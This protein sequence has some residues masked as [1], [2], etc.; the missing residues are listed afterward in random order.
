V[1]LQ[2]KSAVLR[3]SILCCAT[4]F[5]VCVA[6]ATTIDAKEPIRIQVDAT[7]TV[8]KV[9]SVTEFIPL[10]DETS[11]TLLYPRWEVASHAPTISVADLAGLELVLNGKPLEWQRDPVDVHA[12]HVALPRKASVLEAHFQYLSSID[13]PVLSR[14]IVQVQWQHLMLYPRGMNVNEIP[15]LAQLRLPTGFRAASSLRVEKESGTVLDFWQCTVGE[16]ADAPVF[17]GRFLRNWRLS[18]DNAKPVWLHVVADEAKDLTISSEQLQAL[19]KTVTL[20][21]G[22]FGAVPFRH[23]DFLVAVTDQLP[24][25]GGAEHQESSEISLPADYFLRPDK[26]KA[27]ASLFPHEYIHAWNGL[28]HR[29]AGLVVPDFNTPMQNSMLWVY[30]GLTELWGLQIAG[31]SGLI[32]DQDYRDL[33][34]MDAA[35]QLSRPG[36]QWKS[37]ADSDYDPVYLAG[38]HTTWR[39]WERRE[40]YYTEG[41]LLWLGVDAQIRRLTDGRKTLK[42]FGRTFFAAGQIPCVVV[43]YSFPD[44]ISGLNGIAPF[45]WLNCLLVQLN[46]HDGEHLLDD[47]KDA[48][49]QLVFSPM[50]SAIFAQQEQQDGAL[51]L[52][53]SIGARIR[54]NGLVQ[55]VS[56]HSSAFEAGMVPGMRI[57]AIDG[58]TF[59][60]DALRT[61]LQSNSPAR[62]SLTVTSETGEVEEISFAYRAGLR[63]PH[64][65]RNGH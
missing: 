11:I 19:R 5:V 6:R 54:Q 42:D 7:D 63:F 12:F 29:P 20:T 41:P 2:F 8:H 31:E 62:I 15:V 46:A 40:D 17:A 24:S 61:R 18:T 27:M 48:N 1:L 52:S 51:D 25:G 57:T 45:S 43:A 55:S 23:Y 16:L 38:H 22:I 10:H 32:S 21:N 3:F 47:L 33:L 59:N 4:S 13:R 49:Y 30:E 60:F 65:E 50:E 37:L 28:C 9:F 26:Y 39:D 44:L 35:E 53:Y 64:L 56:W 58:E 36:R 34:A 14:N